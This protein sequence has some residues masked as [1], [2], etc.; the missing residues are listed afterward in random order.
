[1]NAILSIQFVNENEHVV[2]PYS[3]Y[4]KGDDFG[5][6]EGDSYPHPREQAD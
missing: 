4:G 5:D 3:Q 1:V 2:H 6:D